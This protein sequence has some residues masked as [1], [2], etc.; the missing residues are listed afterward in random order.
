MEGKREV[1]MVVHICCP[2]VG[3]VLEGETV[4]QLDG[5][6]GRDVGGRV[7]AGDADAEALGTAVDAAHERDGRALG[8]ARRALGDD[9]RRHGTRGRHR[10][11]GKA[12][13]A[14]H[15]DT[16][17]GSRVLWGAVAV[18]CCIHMWNTKGG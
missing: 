17:F 5:A 15:K 8:E 9:A 18:W 12:A 10:K 7:V 11:D 16:P 4:A 13:R 6:V 3:V 1:V 14:A 2:L